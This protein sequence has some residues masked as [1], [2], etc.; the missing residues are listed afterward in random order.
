[1]LSDVQIAELEERISPGVAFIQPGNAGPQDRSKDQCFMC[2]KIGHHG[3]DCMNVTSDVRDPHMAK[4]KK[5]PDEKLDVQSPKV[6]T[7]NA[8]VQEEDDDL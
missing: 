1:M 7:Q 4:H 5:E 3:H 2:G 8:A 6:G